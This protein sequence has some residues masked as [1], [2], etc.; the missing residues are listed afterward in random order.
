MKALYDGLSFACSKKVTSL[1]STSFSWSVRM[2]KSRIRGHIYNIYGFVRL[3]DEIVDSFHGYDQAALLDAFEQD[4][5]SALEKDISLNPIIHAFQLSIKKYDIDLALVEAF[6]KSMRMD[7]APAVYESRETYSDYIYG[8]A[9]VVGLMCLQVFVEG[10]KAKY[11][12][13]KDSA[14]RLGSAFQKINFLRDIKNDLALLNR[15]YFPQIQLEGMNAESKAIII[16]E[17][18]EDL[19]EAYLGIRQLPSSAKFGV[20][21]AYLYYRKLLHKLKST[22]SEEILQKRVRVRNP[23]KAALLLKSFLHVKLNML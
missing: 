14:M 20:Y 23:M 4:F 16:D 7:L 5:Y 15:S 8:S 2:L 22:P 12:S 13:L 19:R 17:I 18:E 3:A 21:T 1:Y 11:E 9:D 6:L 10:D